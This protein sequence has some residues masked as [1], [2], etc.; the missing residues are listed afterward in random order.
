MSIR[1]CVDERLSTHDSASMETPDD[2]GK[3][4]EHVKYIETAV[5]APVRLESAC[6][7]GTLARGSTLSAHATESGV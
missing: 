6:G 4:G 7:R 3:G 2:I 1:R 5:Q